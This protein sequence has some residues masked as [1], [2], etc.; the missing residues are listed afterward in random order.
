M[1]VSASILDCDFLHLSDEL[2]AVVAA[3]ADAVRLVTRSLKRAR[4]VR[5]D[6]SIGTRDQD[7]AH[8]VAIPPAALSSSISMRS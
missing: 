8:G 4:E 6:E 2:S 1:K 3:G 7:A 5:A